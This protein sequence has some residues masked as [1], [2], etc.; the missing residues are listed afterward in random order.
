MIGSLIKLLILAAFLLILRLIPKVWNSRIRLRTRTPREPHHAPVDRNVFLTTIFIHVIGFL[1]IL[2]VS[3]LMQE[4]S[5]FKSLAFLNWWAIAWLMDGQVSKTPKEETM[6]SLMDGKFRWR[7]TWATSRFFSSS[8]DNCQ[9]IVENWL[10]TSEKGVQRG[11]HI[12]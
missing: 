7:S 4:K 10:P 8:S 2:L 1:I 12:V 3:T 5:Y 9:C 11:N 6:A